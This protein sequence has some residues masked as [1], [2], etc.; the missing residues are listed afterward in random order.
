MGSAR[1]EKLFVSS[2]ILARLKTVPELQEYEVE[3]SNLTVLELIIIPD[4]SGGM[5]PASVKSLRAS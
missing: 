5:A 4:L 2:G 1:F 3:L